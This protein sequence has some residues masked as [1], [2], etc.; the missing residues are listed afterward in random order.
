M[1][2]SKFAQAI[3]GKL[4]DSFDKLVPIRKVRVVGE[5][6]ETFSKVHYKIKYKNLNKTQALESI[7]EYPLLDTTIVKSISIKIG[8]EKSIKC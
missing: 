3:K 7:F 8:K 1:L 4:A 5:L 2:A 6:Y